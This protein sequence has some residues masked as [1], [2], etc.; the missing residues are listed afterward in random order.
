MTGPVPAGAGIG[1]RDRDAYFA[2]AMELLADGGCEAVTIARLCERLHV[3]HGSFYH[4]F[5]GMPGFVMSFVEHRRARHAQALAGFAAEPDPT[6]RIE[7]MLDEAPEL[8]SRAEAAMLAWANT[9][10]VVAASVVTTHAELSALIHRTVEEITGDPELA[11]ILQALSIC[12]AWGLDLRVEPIGVADLRRMQAEFTGRWIGMDSRIVHTDVGQHVRLSRRPPPRDP[13]VGDF[14][15]PDLHDLVWPEHEPWPRSAQ[16][17]PGARIRGKGPWFDAARDILA[18][19][20]P[21]GLTVAAL[22]TRLA[23]TKGSFQ[24]HFE[25]M[26]NFVQ[27]LAG[28]WEGT[29][30]ERV[31]THREQIDPADR[32]E[33]LL[34]LMMTAP[35][36]AETAWRA[37]SHTEPSVATALRRIDRARETLI[38]DTIAQV[39]AD[40]HAQMLGTAMLSLE[41]GLRQTKQTPT[42]PATAARMILEWTRRVLELD[43]RIHVVDR[44]PV[45]EIDRLADL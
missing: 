21:E 2:A 29:W 15:V 16:D 43:A 38:A 20:G 4:H 34:Q 8:M 7:L 32:L 45:L 11:E 10:P 22:C 14:T 44:R 27:A 1:V 33:Q 24:W 40:L 19:H 9:N 39:T 6:R 36:L 35:D 42:D 28:H 31:A 18:E 3:T 41:I 5:D 25:S 12:L 13:A 17:R 30:N 37:W 23:V 26:P